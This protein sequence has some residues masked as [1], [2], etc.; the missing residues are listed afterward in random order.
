MPLLSAQGE[1]PSYAFFNPSMSSLIIFNIA[2]ATRLARA[3][4]ESFIISPAPWA[5][6]ARAFMGPLVIVS[7]D[8]FFT[9]PVHVGSEPLQTVVEDFEHG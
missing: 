1:R 6:F 3:R 5:R 4:S 2:S 7:I 9:G 8:H